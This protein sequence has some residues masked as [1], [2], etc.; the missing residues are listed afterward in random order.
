MSSLPSNMAA[1]LPASASLSARADTS[2]TEAVMESFLALHSS[3]QLFR[4]AS[5]RAHV[6]TVAP[7][8]ANSSTMARLDD[9]YIN[10]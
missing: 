7:K 8:L 6:C 2:Q 9:A 4:V 1:T 10:A 3:R 5:F